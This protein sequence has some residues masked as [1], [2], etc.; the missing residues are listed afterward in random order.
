MSPINDENL[1]VVGHLRVANVIPSHREY[2]IS[3]TPSEPIVA[4]QVLLEKNVIKLLFDHVRGGRGKLRCSTRVSGP[5]RWSALLHYNLFLSSPSFLRSP[6]MENIV[7]VVP[8][9]QPTGPTFK[10][11]FRVKGCLHHVQHT[12]GKSS[13]GLVHI[14]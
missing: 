9:N 14:R 4:E 2:M 6:N 11:S 5:G 7:E 13:R 10:E 8:D 1:M 12:F 3:S